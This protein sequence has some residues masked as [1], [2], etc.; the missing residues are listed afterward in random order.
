MILKGILRPEDAMQAKAIGADGIVVSNHGGRNLDSAI[1]P[2][3][4]LRDIAD[5]VGSSMAVL[6]DSSV[7]RGSDIF[8][9]LA[10]GARAVMVGRAMLYGAAA[11][12][13]AGASRMMTILADEL[14]R[15]MDMSGCRTLAD[16]TPDMI[17]T[18]GE[19]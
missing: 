18:P 9:L 1:A 8:K 15:T 2:I 12:R 3:E 7:Q 19:S 13:Q 6:A 11:G 14:A 16:I 4:V 5:S 10:N 17:A